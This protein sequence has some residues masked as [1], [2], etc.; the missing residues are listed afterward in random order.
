MGADGGARL[1]PVRVR[2]VEADAVSRDAARAVC[3]L[4]RS[5]RRRLRRLDGL[6]AACF[7]AGRLLI[8][9]LVAEITGV[10]AAPRL[11]TTC[12]R[13]GD[14]HGPPAVPDVPVV[15]SYAGPLAV[16]AAAHR[17]EVVA[18]GGDVKAGVSLWF[19]QAAAGSSS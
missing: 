15:V 8:A 4:G 3:A 1:G 5:Q 17:D 13:C 2:W 10:T 9:G 12:P 14:E 11:S 19:C 18:R 16:L 7:A 6:A